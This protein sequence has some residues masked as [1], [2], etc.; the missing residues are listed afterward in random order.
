[1]INKYLTFLILWLGSCMVYAQ[2]AYEVRGT[3]K[4]NKGT[5]IPY[6]S[7]SLAGEAAGGHSNEKGVFNIR[8]EK[9]PARLVVSSVGYENKEITVDV[10]TH[11]LVIELKEKIVMLHEVVVTNSKVKPR[12]IGSPKND[13]G[14]MAY[15]AYN[16]FEQVGIIVNNHN[17]ALYTNPKWLSIA[18]K[19]DYRP[20]VGVGVKPDGSR[21]VRLRIYEL[22]SEENNLS[23]LLHDNI[24]A[25]APQKG[26]W[27]TIDIEKYHLDL[28]QEGFIVAVEWLPTV[29]EN[30]EHKKRKRDHLYIKGHKIRAHEREFYTLWQS[31]HVHS[32]TEPGWKESAHEYEYQHIPCIRLEF[33]ELQ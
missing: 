30:P 26:G 12:T 31:N 14:V 7:I 4:D 17:Q 18:I 10:A 22:G 20:L 2:D 13:K 6:A 3:V 5:P 27:T 24:I 32:E 11:N 15:I 1:M 21:R 16:D 29:Y 9:F 19:I 25:V 33:I 8:V 23:D 28:S